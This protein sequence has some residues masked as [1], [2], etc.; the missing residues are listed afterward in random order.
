MTN[1]NIIMFE[2]NQSKRMVVYC[3]HWS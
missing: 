2:S 1:V 3:Y